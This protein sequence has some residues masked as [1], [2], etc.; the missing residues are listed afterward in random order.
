MSTGSWLKAHRKQ[1]ITHTS[2]IVV[3]VLFIIF[4]SEPLFDRLEA[5]Q[6]ESRLHQFSLPAETNDIRYGIDAISPEDP[7]VVEI[8]GWAFIED[9]DSE[10][11]ETYIVL[12][13]ASRTYIFDTMLAMRPDITRNFRELNLNLDQSGFTALIPARKISNGTYTIGIYIRKG[14]IEALQYINRAIRKSGDTI[15]TE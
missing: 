7:R 15:K 1:V 10:G 2:I 11:S 4:V 14:D 9:E 12:E 13:S 6:G 5:V 3:F 8:R